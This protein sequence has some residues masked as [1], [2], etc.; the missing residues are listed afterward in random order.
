MKD[1]ILIF[2][3]AISNLILLSAWFRSLK[4]LD[5]VFAKHIAAFLLDL[6]LIGRR[7]A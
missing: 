1:N 4:M 3:F 6:S 5:K 7:T 2:N